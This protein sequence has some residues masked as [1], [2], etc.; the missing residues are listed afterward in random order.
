MFWLFHQDKD[1]LEGKDEDNPLVVACIGSI[2]SAV[3]S[4]AFSVILVHYAFHVRLSKKNQVE[5]I[6]FGM[7]IRTL[8]LGGM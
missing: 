6:L 3:K 7:S 4:S 2:V 1:D 8:F 5:T